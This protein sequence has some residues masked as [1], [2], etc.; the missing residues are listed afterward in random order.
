MSADMAFQAADRVPLRVRRLP[1]LSLSPH[2]SKI[3]AHVESIADD[4]T[5]LQLTAQTAAAAAIPFSLSCHH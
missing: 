3:P 2:D 1:A 4:R 5:S